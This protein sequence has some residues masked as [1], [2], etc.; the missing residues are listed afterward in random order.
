MCLL[1]FTGAFLVPYT[2]MLFAAG[3]PM[4]VLELGFGQY[5]SKGCVGVWDLA[6][7]F[8]GKYTDINAQTV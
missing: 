8:R 3:L 7:I 1:Y 5:V 6:P 4:F 2:I